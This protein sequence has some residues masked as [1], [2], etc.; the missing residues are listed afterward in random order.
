MRGD[1]RKDETDDYSRIDFGRECDLHFFEPR[2]TRMVVNEFLRQAVASGFRTVR[3]VHGK[4]LS[5]KKREVYEILSG[6]PDVL[7]YGNDGPNW[8]ATIITLKGP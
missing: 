5:A 1:G 7:K 6:H 4:G 3:L 8:G 2:E